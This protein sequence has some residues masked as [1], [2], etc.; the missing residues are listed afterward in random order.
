[1]FDVTIH[2]N[3]HTVEDYVG[4]AYKKA[5]KIHRQLPE[6]GMLVFLTGKE[7]RKWR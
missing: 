7:R 1:M 6:G 4:E 3:K 5:C 2:Y